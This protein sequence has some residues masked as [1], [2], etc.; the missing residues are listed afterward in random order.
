MHRA[1]LK[2]TE[3][4]S[5]EGL[6][7]S[8]PLSVRLKK[9]EEPVKITGLY[10]IDPEKLLALGGDKLER[11]KR[12]GVLTFALSQPMSM[13]HTNILMERAAYL[14]KKEG[15]GQKAA[16]APKKPS[17]DLSDDEMISF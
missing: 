7:V 13:Q 16:P 12:H 17:F 3:V 6:I 4:L 15:A 9:D 1:T 2:A 10:R 8:W 11:L 14:L 5:D